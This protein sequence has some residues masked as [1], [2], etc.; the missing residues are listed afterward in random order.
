MDDTDLAYLSLVIAS[1]VIF[2][3]SLFIQ[4]IRSGGRR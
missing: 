1:F 2:G 4:S 3:V